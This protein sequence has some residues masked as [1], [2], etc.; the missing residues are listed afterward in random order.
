MS[1]VYLAEGYGPTVLNLLKI[2]R[3]KNPNRRIN[4]IRAV[5]GLHLFL[6]DQVWCGDDSPIVEK[7]LILAGQRELCRIGTSR[8][9]FKCD[10]SGYE[11]FKSKY[12]VPIVRMWRDNDAGLFVGL[13]ASLRTENG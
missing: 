12:W 1:Y 2:G 5:T 4:Q 3:S 11:K 7:F 9:F 6:V 8:E 10:E 13:L